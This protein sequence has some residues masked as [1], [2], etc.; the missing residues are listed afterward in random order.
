MSGYLIYEAQNNSWQ[1]LQ[2]HKT[3]FLKID[4]FNIQTDQLGNTNGC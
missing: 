3:D 1:S 2:A 4:D